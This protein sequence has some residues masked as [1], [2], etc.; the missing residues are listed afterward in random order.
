[1]MHRSLIPVAA[2]AILAPLSAC[3]GEEE[4]GSGGAWGGRGAGTTPAVEVVRARLDALP[5]RER[6]TGT[7]RGA[8]QVAIY[9]QT[10]GP[11]TEVFVDDGMVVEA[12]QALVR[13]ESRTPRSQLE[14][15]E[16]ALGVATA[17]ER[18]ARASLAELEAQFERTRLLA[19]DSLVSQETVETERAR[20]EAARAAVEQAVAQVRSAEA[21]I[22]ERAEAVDRTVVRAPI[23]GVVGQRNAEVGMI[24]DGQTPL[25][26]IGQLDRMR[27]E[28]PIAQDLIGRILTGQRAEIRTDADPGRAIVAEVSRL[29]PFLAEGSFS[30]EAEIDVEN[31][32]GQLIPGMFVT[33]DVFYGRS[34]STTVVPVSALY[35]DVASGRTGVY[36]ASAPDSGV[37]MTVADD[38]VGTLT[39]ESVETR[40]VPVEVLARGRQT[41]GI[42]GVRPGEWVVVVGHSLLAEETG[43]RPRARI[44]PTS[45]DRIIALQERQGPELLEE[46]MEEHRRMAR[47][48][49]L[50]SEASGGPTNA[51]GT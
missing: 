8:G 38:G 12:G 11:V 41:A 31:P 25:F 27:V 42:T 29:S 9:P 6:L 14:Q 37:I 21:G 26:T 47:P 23:A 1:M 44:R 18:A 4:T 43:E 33:V 15:A 19:A 50:R 10:S 32:A 30:A 49:S 39:V 17:Q 16:A 7:V 5:L 2:V 45:W 3:G 40:F 22:R 35:D 28:V 36:V 48:E 34:D 24:A 20:V 46:L 13:I 51:R